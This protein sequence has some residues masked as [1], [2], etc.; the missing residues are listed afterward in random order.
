[1]RTLRL[2]LAV[3]AL[4]TLAPAAG[5]QS[6]PAPRPDSL[7][8]TL[9]VPA[10]VFDGT[11]L[12]EGWAVLV[13]G[14]RIAAVGPA[15]TLAAPAGTR[16]VELPRTTLMPGM[17]DAHTHLLLHPYDETSWDDQ[18]LRESLALRVARATN[19]ARATLH[20]GFTTVRDLGTE[21]AGYADVGLKQAIE[22]GIIPG[23]RMIV[24]T[25]AIV[26]TGSYGPRGFASEMLV[27]QGAE[28]ADAGNLARVVRDQIG[29]G[30]DWIK[31]YADY[32][33]GP[34]GEAR[35]TFTVEELRQI[36]EIAATSGRPVVAHASTAEGMRRAII[37]GVE[38]VDHGDAGT[39]DVFR[40]M[41]ERNV[42]L[43]PTVAAGDAI[44]RYRGWKRGDPEPA[45]ITEKRA[46][47]RAALAAGVTFCAGGD[48]GVFTHG[49]NGRELE[50][51][52]DYGLTPLQALRAATTTNARMLHMERQIGGVAP[53]LLADLVALDGDPTRDIS[54]VRRPVFVMKGGVVARQDAR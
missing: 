11:E 48:A 40:L 49:E 21:G 34:N 31:V 22:Q 51:L 6:T 4:A 53:G 12:H 15:A 47:V 10:R 24:T 44:L 18:V 14:A 16:R 9:L 35:P 28:E 17:I 32:R 37:A 25:K 54:A 29:H 46:S 2:A 36:V 43:C 50:L 33:W 3:F 27:P 13:R 8:L 45:R 5:A 41:Q 20:A 23:P 1:L 30:A 42:M 7:A 52:V 19:H 39:P 38:T 26:A